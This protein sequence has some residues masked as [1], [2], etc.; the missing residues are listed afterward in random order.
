MLSEPGRLFFYPNL[1]AC[2]R[3]RLKLLNEI[4]NESSFE[5]LKRKEENP[6]NIFFVTKQVRL[7]VFDRGHVQHLSGED[8]GQKHFQQTFHPAIKFN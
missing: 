7:F 8:F 5:S 4:Q 6:R 2:E 3:K 1:P